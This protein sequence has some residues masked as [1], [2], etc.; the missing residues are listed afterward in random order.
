MLL[1]TALSLGVVHDRQGQDERAIAEYERTLAIEPDNAAARLYLADARL[2]TNATRGAI[3]LY[4]AA[5]A[6]APDT[7]QLPLAMAYI[8]AADW[9]GALKQLEAVHAARPDDKEATNALARVLITAGDKTVLAPARGLELAKTLFTQT[10]SPEVGQTY[11]MGFAAT[12]NFAEAVKLQEETLI[13][14]ERAK[15]HVDRSFLERN[16]A[17]YRAGKPAEGGW[18]PRDPRLNPRNPAVQLQAAKP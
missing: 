6:R 11:A 9:R 8:K 4:Q 13:A 1:R 3:E 14:Y 2:R 17:R 15:L 5:S 12:G 18:S 16:L 10:R 7:M